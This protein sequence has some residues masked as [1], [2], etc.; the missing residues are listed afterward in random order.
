M[1]AVIEDTRSTIGLT[2]SQGSLP[3]DRLCGPQACHRGNLHSIHRDAYVS[4]LSQ[5]SPRNGSH[6][7]DLCEQSSP[8]NPLHRHN[9]LNSSTFRSQSL[10]ARALPNF[11]GVRGDVLRVTR[12]EPGEQRRNEK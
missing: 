8:E 10:L 11:S 4:S 7:G 3:R 2:Q 12:Q 6:L 9:L 5:D 1:D